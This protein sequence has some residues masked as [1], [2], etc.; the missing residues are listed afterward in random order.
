[1]YL[2]FCGVLHELEANSTRSW[3]VST[4]T[5]NLSIYDCWYR[6]SLSRRKKNYSR[7]T[8]FC[9]EYDCWYHSGNERSSI[10]PSSVQFFFFEGSS[11]QTLVHVLPFAPAKL[12]GTFKYKYVR[13]PYHVLLSQHWFQVKADRNDIGA[14]SVRIPSVRFFVFCIR[15]YDFSSC[16][17]LIECSIELF[18]WRITDILHSFKSSSGLHCWFEVIGSS[19]NLDFGMSTTSS[20]RQ[21]ASAG[22]NKSNFHA[23][24][25]KLTVH[26]LLPCTSS[27]VSSCTVV[28]INKLWC[29][30]N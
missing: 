5:P 1:M 3:M 29:S 25:E 12:K 26:S 15:P 10:K 9:F 7:K 14:A 20:A 6:L 18:I 4:G 28:E 30:G 16:P 22:F 11:V 19:W 17:R 24:R 21:L 27:I 13:G 2:Q 23:G 8:Q